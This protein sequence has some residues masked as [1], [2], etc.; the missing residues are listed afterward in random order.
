MKDIKEYIVTENFSEELINEDALLTSVLA[1]QMIVVSTQIFCMG[2][3]NSDFSCFNLI[4]TIKNWWKDIKANKII[5]KLAQDEDIKQFL[6]DNEGKQGKGWR[7]LL[8]S[9]LSENE[10]EYITRITQNKTRSKIK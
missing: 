4:D 3:Q 7:D 8:R 6:K 1:T 2:M 10:Y 5:K 9:K